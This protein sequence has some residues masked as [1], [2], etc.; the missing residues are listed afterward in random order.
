MQHSAPM[1]YVFLRSLGRN[2]CLYTLSNTSQSAPKV[3]EAPEGEQGRGD[4]LYRFLDSGFVL[5]MKLFQSRNSSIDLVV[6]HEVVRRLGDQ[7]GPNSN[8]GRPAPFCGEHD[9]VGRVVGDIDTAE[10]DGGSNQVSESL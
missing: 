6:A 2:G 4:G 9:F 1:R 7:E 3:G 8:G 5:A 10:G